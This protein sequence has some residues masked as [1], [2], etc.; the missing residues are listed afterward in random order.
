MPSDYGLPRGPLRWERAARNAAEKPDSDGAKLYERRRSFAQAAVDTVHARRVIDATR[1]VHHYTGGRFAKKP[2]FWTCSLEHA[3]LQLTLDVHGL[4]DGARPA[5]EVVCSSE[6]E[7]PQLGRYVMLGELPK[8]T[9]R[10]QVCGA[11]ID[12]SGLSGEP[13]VDLD[14]PRVLPKL[15]KLA[16][17]LR[18]RGWRQNLEAVTKR[19]YCFNDFGDLVIAPTELRF[20]ELTDDEYALVGEYMDQTAQERLMRDRGFAVRVV[21]P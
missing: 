19:V 17:E 11:D 20:I 13:T 5:E 10:C 15:K 14:P 3:L 8:R 2:E 18:D 12:T 7:I 9:V 21:K 4:I 1:P 16:D 6:Y